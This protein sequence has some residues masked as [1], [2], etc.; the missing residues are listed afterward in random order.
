MPKT[1]LL[2]L[3]TEQELAEFLHVPVLHV[4]KLRYSGKLPFYRLGHKSIRF[5][6]ERV[7]EAISRLEVKEV[8]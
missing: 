7:L 8:A 5:H 2:R 6:P 1:E 4:R 3:L